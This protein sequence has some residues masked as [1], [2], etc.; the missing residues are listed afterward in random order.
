MVTIR[1]IGNPHYRLQPL[2]RE[3]ERR[4]RDGKLV[5]HYEQIH[6]GAEAL[7]MITDHEKQLLPPR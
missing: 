7:A 3:A 6:N 2:A 5:M 1:A 4:F